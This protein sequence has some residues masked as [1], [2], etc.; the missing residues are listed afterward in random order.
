[1][2]EVHIAKIA[3]HAQVSN[4]VHRFLRNRARPNLDG[5]VCGHT[6]LVERPGNLAVRNPRNVLDN[7]TSQYN[8]RSLEGTHSRRRQIQADTGIRTASTLHL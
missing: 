5:C 4:D 1:M 8:V 3:G 7:V 2:L 6:A